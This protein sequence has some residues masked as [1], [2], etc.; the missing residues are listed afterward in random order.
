MIFN[1]L[2]WYLTF[3]IRLKSVWLKDVLD[4]C[5]SQITLLGPCVPPTPAW[6]HI[7]ASFE[8]WTKLCSWHLESLSPVCFYR[9]I[10][11]VF[12][13]VCV[14]EISIVP[15]RQIASCCHASTYYQINVDV[16]LPIKI[17][18]NKLCLWFQLPPHTLLSNNRP[19]LLIRQTFDCH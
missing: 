15:A 6:L 13:F 16:D 14:S 5:C 9:H 10:S 3:M 17:Q 2:F 8:T 12:C 11:Y 18:S 4:E 7:S 19:S 1:W